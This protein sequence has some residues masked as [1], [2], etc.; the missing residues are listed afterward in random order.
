M[1]GLPGVVSAPVL[2]VAES[3]GYLQAFRFGITSI[4]FQNWPTQRLE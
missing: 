3:P 4:R 1:P 2:G